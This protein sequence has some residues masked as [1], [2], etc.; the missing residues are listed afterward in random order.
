MGYLSVAFFRFFWVGWSSIWFWFRPSFLHVFKASLIRNIITSLTSISCPSHLFT[1]FF[2]SFFFLSSFF[3]PFFFLFLH[4]VF[5]P[6]F[7]FTLQIIPPLLLT[8][9]VSIRLNSLW[10]VRYPRYSDCDTS[11]C[12][13]WWIIVITIRYCVPNK[14]CTLLK[15]SALP[16]LNYCQLI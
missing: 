12:E 5:L 15:Y 6:F 14:I 7:P 13:S 4:S 3:F 9:C 10:K 16:L 2:S 8:R 11:L 1:F